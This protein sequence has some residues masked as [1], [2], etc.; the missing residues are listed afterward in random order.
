MSKPR[1]AQ[2]ADFSTATNTLIA[3]ALNPTNLTTVAPLI[4]PGGRLCANLA[5]T[6]G[7]TD[8]DSATIGY[9]PFTSN[10]VPFWDGSMWDYKVIADA[11]ISASVAALANGVYDVSLTSAGA[12][13]LVAWT[14]TTTRATA[15]TYRNGIGQIGANTW[16]G[17]IYVVSGLVSER[18]ALRG[19]WNAYNR[20]LRPLLK[21]ESSA[22]WTY[23]SATWRQWNNSATN[24]VQVV[25]GYATTIELTLTSRVSLSAGIGLFGIGLD[26]TVSPTVYSAS[27]VTAEV[28]LV[29]KHV[30]FLSAGFHYLQALEAVS[31]GTVTYRGSDNYG[32]RG[33]WPC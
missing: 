25:C 7:V 11:G 17:T 2:I 28:D 10:L 14:N 29:V 18:I 9:A 6:L 13:S 24:R 31:G 30:G 8:N 22:G 33:I 21:T 32:L 23:N 4:P 3:A 15:L 27:S 1:S 26:S 5:D 12:L 20:I 19:V 16:L